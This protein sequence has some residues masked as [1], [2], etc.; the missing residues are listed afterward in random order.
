M[1][2]QRSTPRSD[3]LSP[4]DFAIK[5]QSVGAGKIESTKYFVPGTTADSST[6]I[7]PD[8]MH[9]VNQ[10]VRCPIQQRVFYSSASVATTPRP[11]PRLDR[12]RLPRRHGTPSRPSH[13]KSGPQS[14]RPGQYVIVPA[15][16]A[17]KPPKATPTAPHGARDSMTSFVQI[18]TAPTADTQGAGLL[19]HFDHRRYFFGNLA[20]GT[21][22]AFTQRGVSMTKL[23]KLFLSGPV[24]WQN[25]GGLMGMM[26]TVADALAST[27]NQTEAQNKIRKEAGKA[28]L[29]LVEREL[30]VFG[31]KN[32]AHTVATARHF[33]FRTGMPIRAV[34]FDLDPR[35]AS[36]EV[37]HDRP[38]WED[39]S[40]RVWY[41]P[42][43][44]V[45]AKAGNG[46]ALSSGKKRN[47]DMMI[48]ESENGETGA[49][50]V[51]ASGVG[52]STGDGPVPVDDQK[53]AAD[54]ADYV[55]QVIDSMF[56]S[57]WRPDSFVERKLHD[58][59]LPATVFVRKEGGGI[60]RYK[61]PLPDKDP[62]APNIDVLVRQ[63]WP[64]V[65]FETLPATSRSSTSLCYVVKNKG[66]RGK[67]NPKVA[68]ELG[69]AVT[70]FKHL[71]AG[72]T[73]KGKD[74]VD[75]TPDMVLEAPI[76]GSGFALLEIPSRDYV[77]NFV[78][79]PEWKSEALMD[80]VHVLYW[81]LGASVFDDPAIQSF[82]RDR[83]G[84]RHVV[85]APDVS[86]NMLAFESYATLLT[87]LRRIDPDRFPIPKFDNKFR[88]VS[89]TGPSVEVGRTGMKAKYLPTFQ[90][91][92]A[93]IVPFARLD[94]ALNLDDDVVS[95]ARE[96]KQKVADPAFL[97]EVE[98]A[99]RDIP[100]RDA[101]VIPLGTG[102]ALPSKY[103]NVSATLV[104][105]PGVG[106]YLLDA[107]E[108]TVGQLRRMFGDDEA[109]R[110]LADLRLVLISHMHA[111][112]HLGIA[113]VLGAWH[114]LTAAQGRPDATLA[115]CSP[116][117]MHQ[118]LREYAQVEDI[119][120]A[121]VR[122]ST[123]G[124]PAAPEALA[125]AG[126][127]RV[128]TVF[129]EHCQGATAAVLTW[130][131][132]LKVAYSGD[133]RPSDKFAAVG[134]G[135]TVL[136]HEC[137]FDDDKVDDAREKKHSTMGEAL[138][139]AEKMGARRVLL[140]HFSQR[141]AKFPLLDQREVVT[142]EEKVA[143][144]EVKVKVK[145]QVVLLAFDQMRIKLGEFRHAAA[146]LPALRRMSA[147]CP[148]ISHERRKLVH[149]SSKAAACGS[150]TYSEDES[151]I[152]LSGGPTPLM[153]ND[154]VITQIQLFV[155]ISSETKRNAREMQ[156]ET[157]DRGRTRTH[158][159]QSR[160]LTP[161]H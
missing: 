63:P 99:E 87:T 25:V 49:A 33:I 112:H 108:N 106:N 104:R 156:N 91:T 95:L 142:E 143:D 140:T 89:S 120:L 81:V 29:S 147:S 152:V 100:N 64:G 61:G 86:P 93:D 40:V 136:I 139:V 85:M 3:S 146:F 94:E 92:D 46:M 133:C 48:T 127:Q 153:T 121:R 26:L 155:C 114:R 17:S 128:D 60:Q 137:T 80:R 135:A 72:R 13:L 41:V 37:D 39:D 96:A 11:P 68:K 118:W 47:F 151:T 109:H 123:N 82:I 62:N 56:N 71:A 18:I 101:E 138:A 67:F 107:G 126:L 42:V 116:A 90:V 1:Q 66:R 111:D 119:G 30:E 105:V 145:D 122:F 110:I 58:V 161:Y 132:G 149:R 70:D 57:D 130:P 88:D 150:S 83:P 31:A 52:A 115:L 36:P 76:K 79:R 73:V 102:S 74:G 134:R 113:S 20:Q 160:N 141:Y 50:A 5:L 131:S 9:R 45:E 43:A 78:E 54:D 19:L 22:R 154:T 84:V 23:E 65:R 16:P 124:R 27:N 2:G 59:E 55:R 34:D 75:V 129:V 44:E 51:G 28:Q 15:A 38:D 7:F 77:K 8:R 97:A 158:N 148:P 125:A 69:V 103:R 12:P 6:H 32:L 35:I 117:Q 157:H 159:L 4:R 144:G 21:Q 14:L 53:R 10:V 24:T 98:E